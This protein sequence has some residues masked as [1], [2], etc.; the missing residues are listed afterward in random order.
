MAKKILIVDDEPQ[1]VKM[2][3]YRLKANNYETITAN[4]GQTALD[5]TRNEKPDLI[6]LDLMLPNIEGY[7][8][9][10]M[11]KFDQKY[12]HIPII[13]LTAKTQEADRKTGEDVGANAYMTKP[14]ET[15]EL[16]SKIAKLL[17]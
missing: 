10:R 13:I 3:E 12:K 14:F 1:L 11:L 5:L 6:I 2:I 15:K 7:K 4:D 9:C 8:V 16:L 17:E